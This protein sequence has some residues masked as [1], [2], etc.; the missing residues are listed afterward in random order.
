MPQRKNIHRVGKI[1]VQPVPDAAFKP[2]TLEQLKA[3]EFGV[4]YGEEYFARAA[5][6]VKAAMEPFD[7]NKHRPEGKTIVVIPPKSE[8]QLRHERAVEMGRKGGKARA[9]SLSAKR[10]KQIA[11]MG[12]EARWKK[13]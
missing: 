2:M 8:E 7:L 6:R 13:S 11:E 4:D 10:R 3:Y 5:E 12:A 1:T 9:K